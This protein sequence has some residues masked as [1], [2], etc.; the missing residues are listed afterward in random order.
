VELA[1]HD[2]QLDG[3]RAADCGGDALVIAGARN[4]I[5]DLRSANL[6]VAG[7]HTTGPDNLIVN[8]VVAASDAAAVYLQ[9]SGGLLMNATV[10]NSNFGYVITNENNTVV[11]AVAANNAFSGFELTGVSNHTDVWNL[12]SANNGTYGV[13]VDNVTDNSF[14]G[15]LSVGENRSG[16]CRV[17]NTPPNPGFESQTCL[18]SDAVL[19][20]ELDLSFAWWGKVTFDDDANAD[21]TG[22]AASYGS[23]DDWHGFE[24]PDRVWGADGDT[25]P[26]AGNRG[27]CGVTAQCRIWD[28]SLSS[29]DSGLLEQLRVESVESSIVTHRWT[30]SSPAE[31][32][33]LGGD[34]ATGGACESQFLAGAVELMD[35]EDED[36]VLCD[37]GDRCL[38]GPNVGAFQGHGPLIQLGSVS[39]GPLGV[40]TLLQHED[41]AY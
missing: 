1:G 6:G 29:A 24:R 10:V 31:C 15:L 16:D 39:A 28:W 2:N 19:R 7:L 22:G 8:M 11:S 32:A 9:G 41:T 13:V 40:V 4:R 18:G 20:T 30:T 27:A 12:A 5:H 14:N 36:D 34:L 23:L 33:A 38:Y 37:A 26:H 21:D 17:V 3:V 25:F 35:G